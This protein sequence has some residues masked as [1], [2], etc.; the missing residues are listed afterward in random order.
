MAYAALEVLAGKVRDDLERFFEGRPAR[1]KESLNQ[2]VLLMLTAQT[3]EALKELAESGEV[4]GLHTHVSALERYL[5][6]ECQLPEALCA[7]YKYRTSKY[8]AR[9]RYKVSDRAW[10]YFHDLAR[11]L[12]WSLDLSVPLINYEKHAWHDDLEERFV[13]LEVLL[14]THALQGMLISALEAYLSPRR[15]GRKGYEIYGVNLGM[16]RSVPHKNVRDGVCITRYVS[17]MHSQPQMSADTE[18]GQVVPNAKSL[19]A[20]LRATTT[21]YPQYQ[22]VGDFHSHPYDELYILEEKRGWNYSGSDEE[23]N[24]RITR[25]MSELGQHM[26]VAFV[27]GIARSNQRVT[28]GHYR[29]LR[30]TIQMSLGK[31][32]V[33][34]AAYRSLGS[35]RLT[36]SNIRLGVSGMVG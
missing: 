11:E 19:D 21:L 36:R 20:I 24:I 29:K 35:G 32:R 13:S 16:S 17:V 8:R 4:R 14:D 26:L 22:A 3:P 23:S 12:D 31:C 5:K 6:N 28:R 2:L 25:T 1:L 27:I 34:V 30:N 10:D 7:R 9:R 18:Y 15:P 33:V